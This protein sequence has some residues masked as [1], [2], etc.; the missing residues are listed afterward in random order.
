VKQELG[1]GAARRGR[2][3]QRCHDARTHAVNPL[4]QTLPSPY[5]LYLHPLPISIKI[6]LE[7]SSYLIEH[8]GRARNRL[9]ISEA[10]SLQVLAP[11]RFKI[12]LLLSWQIVH[13]LGAIEEVEESFSGRYAGERFAR[14]CRV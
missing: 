13:Q 1:R 2:N 3:Q 12:G 9:L 4:P 7:S 5:N 11:M 8:F 14:K 10:N 6:H